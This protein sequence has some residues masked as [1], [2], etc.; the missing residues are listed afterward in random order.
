M[1]WEYCSLSHWVVLLK[2]HSCEVTEAI[3]KLVRVNAAMA[4]DARILVN[5]VIYFY[6]TALVYYCKDFINLFRLCIWTT[7]L[8]YA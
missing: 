2:G 5:F 8:T 1:R 4:S 6:C 3:P 7:V